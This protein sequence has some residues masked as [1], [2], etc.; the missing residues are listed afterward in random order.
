MVN[1]NICLFLSCHKL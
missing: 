1:L